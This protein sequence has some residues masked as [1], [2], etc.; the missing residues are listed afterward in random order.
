MKRWKLFSNLI[1][2]CVIVARECCSGRSA[3]GSLRGDPPDDELASL[4]RHTDEDRLMSNYITDTSLLATMI[5][6]WEREGKDYL[7]IWRTFQTLAEV[8]TLQEI[9]EDSVSQFIDQLD[10]ITTYASERGELLYLSEIHRWKAW[11]SWKAGLVEDCAKFLDES[12]RLARDK[13]AKL[14]LN[15]TQQMRE[16]INSNQSRKI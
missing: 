9:T 10:E 3:R 4:L 14:F 12:N 7:P 6:R 8:M 5:G 13:G 16:E 11:I 2:L 1:Y 15:N